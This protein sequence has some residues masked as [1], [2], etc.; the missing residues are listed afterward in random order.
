LQA[1]LPEAL[2]EQ[3][4]KERG[5]PMRA[6]V[7]IAVAA[8]IV[9]SKIPEIEQVAAVAA[10]VQNMF[11]AANALGYGA[12]WKTGGAA[13]DAGI[14]AQFGLTAQDHVVALLYLGTATV[15]GP[16]EQAPVQEA[17]TWL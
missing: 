1:K 15:P 16:L 14:K 13:Y 10:A 11:L 6:P 7:I 4:A 5:K 9:K 8:K 17:I 2:P 3:L 12:M